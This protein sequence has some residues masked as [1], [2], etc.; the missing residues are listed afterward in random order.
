[1]AYHDEKIPTPEE[2]R[3]G[4]WQVARKRARHPKPGDGLDDSSWNRREASRK[5]KEYLRER[6]EQPR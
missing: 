3:E 5:R 6:K 4:Q 1:M 2:Y